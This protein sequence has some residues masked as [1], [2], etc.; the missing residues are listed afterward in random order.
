MK[1]LHI[2]T[3]SEWGGAQH[4]V[5]LLA[6]YLRSEHD[7]SVACAPGGTVSRAFA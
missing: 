2:V 4:I 6:K 1:I 5:Y 7:I 3:L